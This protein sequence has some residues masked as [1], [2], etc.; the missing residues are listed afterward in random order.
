MSAFLL[1]DFAR[2]GP[3][4]AAVH[5]IIALAL[6]VHGAAVGGAAPEA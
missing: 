3:A 4:G 6:V 5:V 2:S 1:V